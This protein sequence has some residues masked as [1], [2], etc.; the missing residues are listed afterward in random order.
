M[1]VRLLLTGATGFLG[2]HVATAA[3]GF[4]VS[5]VTRATSAASSD[6]IALGPSD[7][8][9]ADFARALAQVEPDLVLHC[10]GATHSLGA[11]MCFDSNAVLAAELLEAVAQRKRPPRI[12]LIGSAAEY[13]IVPRAFQPVTE[14]YICTPRTNYGVAKHAQTLPRPCCC[15]GGGCQCS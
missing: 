2:R 9:R 15:D 13:G 8:T 14:T 12:I 1:T 6:E 3:T 7:W 4:A 11:R 10:A 5:R